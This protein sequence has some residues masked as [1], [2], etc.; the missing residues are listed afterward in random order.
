LEERGGGNLLGGVKGT[1]VGESARVGY[2]LLRQEGVTL[3]NLESLCALT[4][5]L[6]IF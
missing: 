3:D 6:V 5:I 2:P 4:C 1:H